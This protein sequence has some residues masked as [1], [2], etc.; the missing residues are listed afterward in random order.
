MSCSLLR[1]TMVGEW[2][3][4]VT[5]P[6][7]I[8]VFPIFICTKNTCASSYGAL[9]KQTWHVWFCHKLLP[10]MESRARL[11]GLT[12]MSDFFGGGWAGEGDMVLHGSGWTQFMVKEPL[13]FEGC[14]N[15]PR[16]TVFDL[17]GTCYIF[18]LCEYM[19][20]YSYL[21]FIFSYFCTYTRVD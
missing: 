6:F 18:F 16:S 14:R 7:T 4:P 21:I 1:R 17:R 13:I 5:L 15:N 11:R 10:R 2:W 9:P 19:F 3:H 20:E 8:S 12:S